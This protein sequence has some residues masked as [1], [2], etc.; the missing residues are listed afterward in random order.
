MSWGGTELINISISTLSKGEMVEIF[1]TQ[2][3]LVDHYSSI[4]PKGEVAYYIK[5]IHYCIVGN[6]RG[7]ISSWFSWVRIKPQMFYP[8]IFNFIV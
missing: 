4:L 7:G 6:F 3:C 5:V 8:R 2:G 1:M